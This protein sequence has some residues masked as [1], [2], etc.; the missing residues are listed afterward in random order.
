MVIFG[1][2]VA[3]T[4]NFRMAQKGEVD[5]IVQE[6]YMLGFQRQWVDYALKI[7]AGKGEPALEWLLSDKYESAVK[8]HEAKQAKAVQ[9]RVSYARTSDKIKI[10]ADERKVE[11]RA[12]PSA[13]P[14]PPFNPAF[15]VSQQS[16][17]VSFKELSNMPE[18][19][20][21]GSALSGNA[22]P[23]PLRRTKTARNKPSFVSDLVAPSKKRVNIR[24]GMPVLVFSQSAQDWIPGRIDKVQEDLIRIVYGECQKWLPK[25]SKVWRQMF[26]EIGEG[27]E[28]QQKQ[29]TE[30]M[31]KV[32]R[33]REPSGARYR[34]SMKDYEVTFEKGNPDFD[35]ISDIKGMH[36]YVGKIRSKATRRK[37]KE[38]SQIM[39][40]QNIAVQGMKSTQVL[41]LLAKCV[42]GDSLRITFRFVDSPVFHSLYPSKEEQDYEVVFTESFLGLE[43]MPKTKDGINAVVKK[44]H[45][46]LAKTAVTKNSYIT[47][48]NNKWVCNEEY[49]TIKELLKDALTLPP[50]IITFRAPLARAYAQNERGLLLVKVVAA[51]NL[52]SQA[53]YAQV[54]VGETRLSTRSRS[55][56]NNV[57]WQ[58][59]LGF[60]NFRPKI[61]KTATVYVYE[62]RALLGDN[63]VG[64]CEYELPTRFSSMK[65]DTVELRD[66]KDDVTGLV[67]LQTIVKPNARW[68]K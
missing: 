1:H 25:I 17:K 19:P 11:I 29:I 51:L 33:P 36:T 42:L 60:K 62:T 55:K 24:V 27:E 20:R 46:E 53:N 6:L 23:P 64:S 16:P 50:T 26:V 54:L 21:I 56:N 52:K 5:P 65:R 10:Q 58:E 30:S 45:S 35:V 31:K 7:N 49:N 39:V 66:Q 32:L 14:P 61:G 63:M 44:R 47:S 68:G 48:V 34:K 59:K 28:K 22:G 9:G 15:V 8:A 18:Q 2:S 43:L 67:V 13:P 4:Q 38:G 37:I 3:F 41:E 12:I 40:V 57:E